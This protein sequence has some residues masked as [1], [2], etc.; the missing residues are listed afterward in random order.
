M[1]E[2]GKWL[3]QIV[4]QVIRCCPHCQ[5]PYEDADVRLLGQKDDSWILSLYCRSCHVLAVVGL[6]VSSTGEL[7][8]RE[9]EHFKQAPP[10]T[11][12]DLLDMHLFLEHF[13]GDFRCL[14]ERPA[15]SGKPPQ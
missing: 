10:L 2:Q 6:G 4:L 14:T 3:R 7:S 9:I 11:S 12:D 8:P 5:R 13:D 15:K 1:S